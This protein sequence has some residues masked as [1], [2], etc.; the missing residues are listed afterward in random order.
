MTGIFPPLRPFGRANLPS[1]TGGEA[2]ALD[3]LA[4]QDGGV[5]Q[6][7]LMENAG[8]GSAQ[9]LDRLFPRG[10]VVGVVG[11]GNNGG[12]ALVL[13]RTL[14]AWGRDVQAVLVADRGEGESLF[15]GWSFPVVRDHELDEEGWTTLLGSAGVIVD[16]ILGT[17]A[18]G[19]PRARQAAAIVRVN[20]AER[21]VLSIDVPSGTCA[22]T[23]T[24][25]GA[26]VAADVTIAFGAP[27]LGS[28]MHPARARTGRLVAIEI[29]F[30]PWDDAAEDAISGLVL[31]PAWAYANAPM[32]AAD[33]HKNRVGRVLVVAGRKGMAGAAV[34]A[35]R[36]AL[37]AGAGSLRVCS[38]EENR[39]LLQAAVPEAI[40]V[41]AGDPD[42]I[43]EALKAVD[44]VVIG[45]GLGTDAAARS[46]VQCVVSG[47][48]VALVVD[49]DA[50]NL[51]AMGEFDLAA[52]AADRSVL[53]TPHVGEMARLTNLAQEVIMADRLAALRHAT[54]RFGHAVLLKGAPSLV[55]AP[56]RR[57]MVDTQGTSDLAA[58]GMGDTLAGVCGTFLAQG[59]PATT[60]GGLGLFFLGRAARIAGRGVSLTPS[61]VIRWLPDAL[62]ER[63]SGISDL[64]LPGVVFDADQAI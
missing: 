32:R 1:P 57:V 38:C 34:L 63:G 11:S 21:P 52:L 19:A 64:Q 58:A 4:I 6:S 56:G 5:P 15:H 26:A 13:L 44:V 27:K 45:P 43:E 37:S 39:E 10:R 25:P 8:R 22:D 35:V 60:A 61:D 42:A 51:A 50:L 54:D 53:A 14:S 59:L 49:A 24:V 48:P 28:L 46:V 41:D 16:G 33:T 62:N 17:G 30:P 47:P 23:G 36:G 55:S 18:R 29:G 20:G 40:F 9:V 31:T 7:V 12:D 3:R 2:A